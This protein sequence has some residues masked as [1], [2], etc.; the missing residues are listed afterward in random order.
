[1]SAERDLLKYEDKH[2]R[3]RRAYDAH[4]TAG[5]QSR[6]LEV[7]GDTGGLGGRVV[8]SCDVGVELENV[9][10]RGEISGLDA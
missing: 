3:Q 2:P 6:D 8:L 10:E 7:G 4:G 1:M 5:E 9:S